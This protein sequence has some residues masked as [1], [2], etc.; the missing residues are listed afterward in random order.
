MEMLADDAD[1]V[2]GADT[3]RD[4][5]TIAALVAVSGAVAATRVIRA[6]ESGYG[7]ALRFADGNAPGRRAWALEGTGSYGAGFARFLRAHGERV[8]EIDRPVRN[9]RP[10]RAKNDELD[11]VRAARTALGRNQHA[12]PRDDATHDALRAL[13]TTREGA[14]VARTA[15]I[16]QLRALVVTAPDELR[17]RLRDQTVSVLVDRAKRLRVGPRMTTDRRGAIV[18]IRAVANRIEQLSH[19]AATVE[20]E[21]SRLVTLTAPQ[22]LNERGI[23]ALSAAQILISWS[24]SGR[25]STEARFASLAGAAPIVASSG[26]TTRHRLNRGGDRKLNRTLHTIA[27]SRLRHDPETIS[28]A[29]RRTNEGKSRREIIRCLKRYLA[30]HLW[31]LLEHTTPTRPNPP[32]IGPCS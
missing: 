21:I 24:Q 22:L 19:E 17:T 6:Q 16:N 15:A 14:I 10:S 4:Q 12:T 32:I 13:L 7:A 30:R 8:L 23:G 18:A 31:R 5:H 26:L 9:D 25:I 11:A 20:R 28:Y 3:H 1:F 29:A 2:L 27:L